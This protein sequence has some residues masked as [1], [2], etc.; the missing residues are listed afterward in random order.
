MGGRLA[1]IARRPRSSSS[2]SNKEP[3]FAGDNEIGNQGVS[4]LEVIYFDAECRAELTRMVL[5]IAGI[6]FKDTRISRDEWPAVKRDT[7]SVPGTFFGTMPCIKHGDYFLAQ[8]QATAFYAAQ[9]GIWAEGFIGA[10]PDLI[11]NRVRELMILSVHAELQAAMYKCHYGT[12][13][14]PDGSRSTFPDGIRHNLA[15]LERMLLSNEGQGGYLI[16]PNGPTV[17]DLAVYNAVNSSFPG[18]RKLGET[19]D[20]YPEVKK[21]VDKVRVALITRRQKPP[22]V[23]P[24]GVLP[25]GVPELIYFNHAGRAE[26]TRLAFM[27]G[28]IRFTD[29]RLS[30][31]EWKEIKKNPNSVPARLFG[32]L[33]CLQHGDF[34]IA[35]SHATAVYAAE[36]GIWAQG[37][38]GFGEDLVRNRADEIMVLGAHADLQ[39]VMS[40]CVTGTQESKQAGHRALPGLAHPILIGLERM[41]RRKPTPGPYFLSTHGPTLSDLAV[42]D[43]V[44]SPYPG[45]REL[46]VDLFPYSKVLNLVNAVGNEPAL[47]TYL[48]WRNST[49]TVAGDPES[50]T[51]PTRSR[52]YSFG[53]S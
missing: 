45:L 51:L 53:R 43:A 2:D 18:L 30:R 31:S 32:T 7:C 33:P 25:G 48:S 22:Q 39:A 3:V 34:I 27:V 15:G 52:R 10:G 6:K 50:A 44:T 11:K 46:G 13:E 29:T 35:Q 12:G 19:L 36:L 21:L 5:R 1:G 23:R 41:L 26:V 28:G 17:A 14:S 37:R 38:I 9:L 20:D 8:S 47:Q 40:K 49:P 4:D 42:F 24:T 16:S